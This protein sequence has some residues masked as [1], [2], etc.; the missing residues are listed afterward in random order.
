METISETV[1]PEGVQACVEITVGLSDTG[2]TPVWKWKNYILM[3]TVLVMTN[4]QEWIEFR[5]I[6]VKLLRET[7][8]FNV[9]CILVKPSQTIVTQV[10]CTQLAGIGASSRWKP[11]TSREHYPKPKTITDD[12]VASIEV[13]QG[14]NTK[15]LASSSTESECEFLE[16]PP[17]SMSKSSTQIARP[18]HKADEVFPKSQA[19]KRPAEPKQPVT[20]KMGGTSALTDAKEHAITCRDGVSKPPKIREANKMSLANSTDS[21]YSGSQKSLPLNPIRTTNIT[22]TPEDWQ[23]IRQAVPGSSFHAN[24]PKLSG[25]IKPIKKI[26]EARRVDRHD[27][28]PS[29]EE[30]QEMSTIETEKTCPPKG[31]AE[32]NTCKAEVRSQDGNEKELD[33]V[34]EAAKRPKEVVGIEKFR[35]M[36]KIVEDFDERGIFHQRKEIPIPPPVDLPDVTE[37][38]D[39]EPRDL[40]SLPLS[41]DINFPPCNNSRNDE[42][43]P[44]ASEGEDETDELDEDWD[45]KIFESYL[46]PEES[47]K[48]MEAKESAVTKRQIDQPDGNHSGRTPKKQKLTTTEYFKSLSPPDNEENWPQHPSRDNSKDPRENADYQPPRQPTF[49]REGE[50]QAESEKAPEDDEYDELDSDDSMMARMDEVLAWAESHVIKE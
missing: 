4:D 28:L 49:T 45:I 50:A 37:V 30:L 18:V 17:K 15:D 31:I 40:K 9:E 14:L 8:Q 12:Q 44:Q 25:R 29:L 16:K 48:A 21:Q 20:E 22:R 6:Q 19:P 47:Q 2:E 24:Q 23:K 3:A 41:P 38:E 35:N 32:G 34:L 42:E 27:E 7:K 33:L 11:R 26:P 5:T 46:A 10:A 36:K 39:K 13:L 43:I 1:V